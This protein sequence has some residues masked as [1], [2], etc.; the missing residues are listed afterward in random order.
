MNTL[1]NILNNAGS[2]TF[3]SFVH[4]GFNDIMSNYMNALNLLVYAMCYYPIE[5]YFCNLVWVHNTMTVI[6]TRL[7]QTIGLFSSFN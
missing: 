2:L 7:E 5:I 1:Y 4:S 3:E 6:M